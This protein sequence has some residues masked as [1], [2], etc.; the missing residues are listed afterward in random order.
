MYNTATDFANFATNH[1]HI[2]GGI[3]CGKAAPFHRA[4]SRHDLG[5]LQS[6]P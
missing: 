2:V 4:F 1:L 3:H 6:Y 5:H